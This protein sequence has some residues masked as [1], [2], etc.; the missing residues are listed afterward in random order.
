MGQMAVETATP[1]FADAAMQDLTEL[2]AEIQR[3]ERLYYVDDNPEI[4]DAE[5]DKLLRKLIDIEERH[6]DLVTPDSPSQRV[7]GAPREGVETAEH[8]SVLLSLDNAFND[9][10]LRNFDRRARELLETEVIEY[11]GEYKFDGVSMA[12]RY[13][14]GTVD[15][16]L[17]RG[18]GH[19]G[20][21]V[22]PNARTIRSLPLSLPP[23]VVAK[24][25]L[26]ATLEVRGEV[27]MPKASFEKLNAARRNE[28][29]TLFKNPRN[30]AAGAL[31]MLAAKETAKRRLDF[32]GY[33]LLVEGADHFATQAEA[34]DALGLLGFRVDRQRRVLHGVNDLIEFR[35]SCLAQRASLPYEIDGV[36]FKVNDRE[37]RTQL[38]S[39]SKAP[40]WA[41]ACKPLAEQVET[42]V[43]DID[44]QVGRTGAI[45]PRALLRPVE[46]G[47]VTVARATL[48]NQDEIARLGLQVGDRVLLERSGDVIPKV[49][50][51]VEEGEDRRPFEMPEECPEC[52]SKVV[53]PDEEAV[54]R[55]V[56]SACRGR[57]RAAI[58]HYGHRSAMDIDGI[59]EVVVRELVK[60]GLVRD[61][62]D[63][64]ALTVEALA[65]LDTGTPM[66]PDDAAKLIE[67]IRD[68]RDNAE[69]WKILKG[70]SIPQVGG[71]TVDILR[72]HYDSLGGLAG[73]SVEDL[74]K[75]KG[76]STKAAASIREYFGDSRNL[77]LLRRF[78]EV[79]VVGV[80]GSP[81][82][83]WSAPEKA[84]AEG[85]DTARADP[86][87]V[88]KST[89]AVGL[90]VRVDTDSAPQKPRPAPSW[91]DELFGARVL[92][93]PDGIFESTPD[94][95]VGRGIRL[96]GETNARKIIES[97]E[98]S[99]RASLA[100]LGMRS[101]I[102]HIGARTAEPLAETCG[103]IDDIRDRRDNSEWRKIP[104]DERADTASAE[105]EDV[106]G[107]TKAFWLAVRGDTDS[108]PKKPR[109]A[110]RVIDELFGAR[111]LQGPDGIF[112]L[113][114]EQ[115]VGRGV[116][117]LGRKNAEKIF[118]SIQES[119]NMPLASL[120]F[121]LG[122]RHVG[123]RTAE[124]LVANFGSLDRI[125][126]ASVDE[127]AE[128]EEV[129]PE[130][131]ESVREFFRHDVNQK[132][133]NRLRERGLNFQGP[134]EEASGDTPLDGKS[135]VLTGA[136]PDVSR[137]EAKKLIQRSGGKVVASVSAKIDF[138]LAG[139]KPGSKLK[140]ARKHGVPVIGWVELQ[141]ML[142]N[143]E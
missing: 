38:G 8:S 84:D 47:G 123:A 56:E 128:V 1:L 14:D 46:V 92:H 100:S 23:D 104:D 85:A 60:R 130:I 111:V 74:S 131:A 119:K 120:V 32:H 53:R 98:E 106:K 30:A 112:E 127:L 76:V 24:F 124:L 21:V 90:A 25:G 136:L 67:E 57:L 55:C 4:T 105:S 18:D 7:G 86:E 58:E 61:I 68:R 13:A 138:L 114:S 11:V 15:L 28:K 113:T 107:S 5:F 37:L 121:G 26:P 116:R 115:L 40:R 93:G 117:L 81:L 51:V 126:G 82:G 83:P 73:A 31:R 64:Y 108:A 118:K 139:E 75:I 27:V 66:T 88:K 17:T 134:A 34:L 62:A 72:T 12:V 132:L 41:V 135:F 89:K 54:V 102:G 95:L 79:G 35:D 6:P 48:H 99:K 70:L 129:G 69:W 39:T 16:A 78:N 63:L 19:E 143:A 97:I 2:R 33:M 3:H 140:N 52:G 20:E 96:L 142:G 80:Q 122:I 94:Q 29:Q 110:P 71:K 133:I 87:Q 59:G 42:V 22:T 91:I 43:E 137:E 109:L 141:T 44:V 9:G 10:E 50:R 103:G 125:R 77:R 36:V 49:V 65:G 101:G 45:T